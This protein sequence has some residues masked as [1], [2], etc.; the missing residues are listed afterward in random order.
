MLLVKDPSKGLDND[1]K[2]EKESEEDEIVVEG[3]EG[4][5]FNSLAVSTGERRDFDC[6]TLLRAAAVLDF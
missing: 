4:M 1:F 6:S 5:S 3:Y 2:V